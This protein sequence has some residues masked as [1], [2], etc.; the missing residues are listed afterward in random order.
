MSLVEN[1]ES[2]YLYGRGFFNYV[3][4]HGIKSFPQIFPQLAESAFF[5]CVY[6]FV[7]YLKMFATSVNFIWLGGFF[8]KSGYDLGGL[9]DKKALLTNFYHCKA[10]TNLLKT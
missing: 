10:F 7:E 1:V 6:F 5:M 9:T 8:A 4:S 3:E 2:P